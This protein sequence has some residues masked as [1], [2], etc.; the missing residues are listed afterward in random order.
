MAQLASAGKVSM[1]VSVPDPPLMI[2]PVMG[3]MHAITNNIKLIKNELQIKIYQL[4]NCLL[5]RY[6]LLGQGGEVEAPG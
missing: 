3:N 5:G 4:G 1:L 2:N 6:W